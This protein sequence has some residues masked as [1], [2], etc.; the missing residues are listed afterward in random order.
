ME[1][2]RSAMAAIKLQYRPG[3]FGLSSEPNLGSAFKRAYTGLT[4][5]LSRFFLSLRH[6]KLESGG[7][8]NGPPAG[9]SFFASERS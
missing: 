8:P 9:K 6:R 2:D 3:E 5:K 1:A 7:G 4:I